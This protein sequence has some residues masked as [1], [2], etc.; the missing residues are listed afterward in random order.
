MRVNLADW[1]TIPPSKFIDTR[2]S[3]PDRLSPQSA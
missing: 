3:L 2:V 1:L